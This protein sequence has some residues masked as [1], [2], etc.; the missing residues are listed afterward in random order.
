LIG[1]A[2]DEAAAQ[3]AADIA[4]SNA[5]TREHNRYKTMLGRETIVRAL[6]QAAAMEV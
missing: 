1:R 2:P 3:L 5:R 6:L 4:F